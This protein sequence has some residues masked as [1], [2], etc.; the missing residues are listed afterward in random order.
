MDSRRR[1]SNREDQEN[2]PTDDCRSQLQ[3]DYRRRRRCRDE[4]RRPPVRVSDGQ[5]RQGCTEADRRHHRRSEAGC[6]ADERLRQADILQT[7]HQPG[8]LRLRRGV[9]QDP[10]GRRLLS[11]RSGP[12]RGDQLAARVLA[13]R[14]GRRALP[15]RRDGHVHRLQD[16]PRPGRAG[17]QRRAQDQQ[18]H[19][20][21]PPEAGPGLRHRD[22]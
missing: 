6:L 10:A 3:Y 19:E 13:P 21:M 14:P 16:R 4:L 17:H 15:H 1:I 8:D 2:R 7:R 12:G 20:R 9:R 5:R 18:V 22:L 11:R